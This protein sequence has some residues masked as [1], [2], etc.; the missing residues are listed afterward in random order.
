MT[1]KPS[2]SL[3]TRGLSPY[4]QGLVCAAIVLLFHAF[5]YIISPE[6]GTTFWVNAI[7]ILLFY[8]LFN[9]V[10]SIASK[11]MNQYWFKSIITYV[12]LCLFGGLTAWMITGVSIDDAGSFRWLYMVFTLGYIIFLSLVRAMRKIV[13]MAQKQDKRLRGED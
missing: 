13:L 2:V 10:L 5:A 12:A 9:S 3:F 8:A 7:A 1:T 4:K 6:K 11:D